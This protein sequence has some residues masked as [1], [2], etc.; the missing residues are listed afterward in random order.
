MDVTL[1]R[2]LETML[3]CAVRYGLGRCSYI[4]SDICEYVSELIPNLSEWALENLKRDISEE[5]NS[6][7]SKEWYD[8]DLQQWNKLLDL[9]ENEMKRKK[10]G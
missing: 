10:D 8:C 7:Y 5:I 1:N 9:V 3:L 4:V 6:L 2:Q